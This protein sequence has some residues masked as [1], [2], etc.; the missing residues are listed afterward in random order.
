MGFEQA[1]IGI[2]QREQLEKAFKKEYPSL[3]LEYSPAFRHYYIK[4]KKGKSESDNISA[5]ELYTR[6]IASKW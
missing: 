3:T 2:K 4:N 6:L 5:Y 1:I